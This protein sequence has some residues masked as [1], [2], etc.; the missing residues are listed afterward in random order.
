MGNHRKKKKTP[1]AAL[2]AVAGGVITLAA[3]FAWSPSGGSQ[4]HRAASAL[5]A[6]TLSAPD[7]AAAVQ[8]PE[9]AVR[10]YAV[11]SG[12]TLWTIAKA[13][14]HDGNKW[15]DLARASHIANGDVLK[16]GERIT[17]SC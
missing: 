14:C 17:V 6:V 2:A 7:L 4:P 10:T 16:I 12:D 11:R 8:V 9:P 15:H 13:Q 1:R 3:L 5:P